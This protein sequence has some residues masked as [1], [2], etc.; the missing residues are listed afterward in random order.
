MAVLEDVVAAV[1]RAGPDLVDRWEITALVEASGYSD[2]RIQEE[3]QL[4]DSRALAQVVYE[5]LRAEP[6]PAV[7]AA[8]RPSRLRAIGRGIAAFFADFSASIIYAV[9]WLVM[10]WMQHVRPDAFAVPASL[11]APMML[12][13]MG[14]LVA[15]A[16]IVQAIVRKGV[17]YT[18]MEQPAVAFRVTRKLFEIGAVGAVI[19][20]IVAAAAALYFEMF[21]AAVL[22]VALNSYVTLSLLWMMCALITVA[23]R[24]WRVPAVFGG[25]AAAFAALYVGG[26]GTVASQLGASYASLLA[27]ALFAA[28]DRARAGEPPVSFLPKARVLVHSLAPYMWYGTLYFS[29]L[30]ADRM[31][32]GTARLLDG[33]AFGVDAPY[34]QATEVALVSFLIMAAVVEYLNSV[35]MRF[36]RREVAQR[37]PDDPALARRVARRHVILLLVVVVLFPAVDVVCRSL[38]V[39]LRPLAQDPEGWRVLVLA[40]AG[41][42]CLATGLLNS[43]ILLSI[44]RPFAVVSSFGAALAVNV[45]IGASAAALFGAPYAAF[46]LTA[47]AAWLAVR[48]TTRVSTALASPAHTFAAL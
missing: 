9:P 1:R 34:A 25:G 22:L 17:F 41:Y 3:L 35:F 13:L 29:L 45:A 33:E 19:L 44:N 42:L 23:G 2:A 32:A 8:R 46:G 11:T 15:T 27:T 36:F 40:S 38:S 10:F 26:A 31:V 28:A 14:S 16:G 6:R 43:L 4:P 48:T 20:G 18:S 7:A 12:A 37:A 30:F 24:R 21:P 39:S 5:R 47:G